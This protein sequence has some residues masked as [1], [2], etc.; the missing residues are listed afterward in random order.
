MWLR[1][2]LVAG[3]RP[4]A[5]DRTTRIAVPFC[6]LE[7]IAGSYEVVDGKIVFL[8]KQSG[9]TTYDLLEFHHV[10]DRS[11]QHYVAHIA[12]IDTGAQLV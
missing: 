6:I 12:C 4:V 2:T 11:H 3:A 8:V 10:V 9:T 5:T 7:H 1:R